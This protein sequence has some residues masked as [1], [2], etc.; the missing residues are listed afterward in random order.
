VLRVSA[1]G[2]V[3]GYRN[4][5]I[6]Y[7][8]SL[9]AWTGLWM[10][11]TAVEW[12]AWQLTHSP[13]WVG[14]MTFANLAP[15]VIASP[16]AGAAADRVDR[17][18]MT[19][20]AQAV[21][22]LQGAVL[23]V[24]TF[25]GLIEI[26][27]LVGLQVVL[28]L[29]QAFSQ[30]ARQT[31]VPGLV[32]RAEV[33]AAVAFNS[34]CYNMA[35][36]IGPA[37]AGPI[38]AMWGVAP[39]M[40]ANAAAYLLSAAALLFLSLDPAIRRGHAATA[41]VWADAREGM[42]YVARHPGMGPLIGFAGVIGLTM[43]AIPEMLPPYT[44]VLF[45]RGAQGFAVLSSTMGLAALAGGLVV[46]A[47]GRLEGL[48]RVTLGAGIVLVLAT[49][50]FVGTPYFAVA[51]LCAAAIGAATTMHGIAAQTLLQTACAPAMVGRTLSLWGLITRAAPALGAV[52]FGAAAELIGLRLPVMIACGVAA[53][54]WYV[55]RGRLSAM[56]AT[57]E[58][59]E[60]GTAC[61]GVEGDVEVLDRVDSQKGSHV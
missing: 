49:A 14:V 42:A 1:I 35:R 59:A 58:R 2:R 38:I 15:S 10:Q 39:T 36:F 22:G 31:L 56:R 9:G 43:R 40:V 13:F 34:L 3:L 29:A 24:L 19:V 30:P 23:A 26:G 6:F 51:V 48:S 27:S 21:I 53:G 7:L 20:K 16:L 33:P 52:S 45:G 46:A 32:P 5:R 54:A 4:A 61:R 57:L 8:S 41:S 60:T 18:W 37:L 11:R 25:S 12:L 44:A 47:R 55:A 17:L 28:G 50:L